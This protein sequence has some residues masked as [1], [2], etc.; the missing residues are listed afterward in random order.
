M[1][2]GQRPPKC[3]YTY[4]WTNTVCNENTLQ[5]SEFCHVH[6]D[7]EPTNHTQENVLGWVRIGSA[8]L[9][10]FLVIIAFTGIC[11]SQDS[12]CIDTYFYSKDNSLPLSEWQKASRYLQDNC[13]LD[14]FGFPSGK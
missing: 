1:Y 13:T 4:T 11:E 3:R 5:G 12:R 8:I 7:Q 10:A 2:P 6:K 9:I 14:Q